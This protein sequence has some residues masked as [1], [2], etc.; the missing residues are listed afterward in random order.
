MVLTKDASSGGGTP[1]YTYDAD[2]NLLTAQD[3]GGTTTYAY[4][5]LDQLTSLT[6]EAGDLWQFGYNQAGERKQT[7]FDTNTANTSWA[8]EFVTSYDPGG[9]ISRIQDYRDST[10]AD[11]V[12]DVSYCYTKYVSGTTCPT[13]T[14]STDTSLVQYSV[15]NQTSAV[16]QYSYDKGSRLTGA[17]NDGGATYSYT[18]NYDG[19][20]TAGS[21]AGAES[22]NLA[23]QITNAGYA[24]DGA[25]NTTA[26]PGNGASAYNDAG[27]LTGLGNA[28]G[29]G[30]ESFAYAG[31]SQDQ[32]LS[33]GSATAI[34][35]GLA[36]QDG[37]PAITSYAPKGQAADYVIRDQQ[38]DSL[39]YVQNGA[40]YAYATDDLGS[41]TSVLCTAGTVTAG[42]AYDPYGHVTAT[43]GTGYTNNLISFTGALQDPGSSNYTHLGDRWYNP[44][45]A[46][47]TS[48]DQNSTLDNPANGNRYAYAA[49]NPANNIDPTGANS[50]CD[51]AGLTIGIGAT[52]LA[53]VAG[54][55]FPPLGVALLVGSVAGDV[56]IGGATEACNMTFR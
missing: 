7:W 33:D 21:S 9:R 36:A 42:Y 10:T 14:A 56:L 4:N 30:A 40:G 35:Y 8:A 46:N 22:Y 16:S 5:D 53:G 12:S 55:L 50:A 28:G 19:D 17:T 41:V 34:T 47:F 54:I 48:Q 15:N 43:T 49:D 45:T 44:V 2:G 11:V 27:Q 24:Y 29:S 20:V 26:A 6:D 25:G 32:L 37:Q 23:N 52:I 13:P 38:G 1:T 3:A 39:G 51:V 18:Y 31:D